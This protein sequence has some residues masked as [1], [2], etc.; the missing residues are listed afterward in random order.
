[1]SSGSSDVQVFVRVR[2]TSHFAQEVIRLGED[3]KLIDIHLKKDE[4]LGMVNNKR[5]DWSFKVDGILHNASQG[6]MYDMVAK[7]VVSRALQGYNGTIMCYGQTG[8]GKTFTI[9]GATENYKNRGII[10]RALQQVFKE[11]DEQSDRTVTVRIS[12]LEIYNE[13]LFDL[14]STLPE[15]PASDT[16]MTIVDDSQGVFVKGLSLHHAAD[17]EHALNLLFEGETN[18]IIGSHTLNK[19]SSRSHC[20]FT[21][22][23]ESHSRTLSNAKYT[24]SKLNLVDLAGS[25]RLGKTGSEGQVLKEASYIN[26]SLSFLEQTIIALADRRDYIP[27]RQSKLTHALKDSIGGNCNTIL[28]ANVYGEAAQIVETLSTLR[29]ASRMKCIPA[30][31]VIIERYDPVRVSKNLQREIDHLRRELAVHDNLTKHSSSSYEPFTDQQI[32]EINSQV[33]RYLDGT[34]DE[35]DIINLRQIQE[36]F[37]QFKILLNRQE[38]EVEARLREKYKLIDKNDYT[39]INAAQKA[40]VLDADGQ[41]VG[42]VDGSS[43][44]IGLAPV[45]SKSNLSLSAKKSKG[46]KSKEQSSSSR[47]EDA[48]SPAI[49]KD[50]DVASP[51]KTMMSPSFREL[52]VKES[53][54]KEQQ[55]NMSMDTQR[56]E[57]A[58]REETSGPGT[59]PTKASAFEEFK[60]ER[61]SELNRIFKENKLTLSDQRRKLKEVTERINLIKKEIDTTTQNL[62]VAKLER[63]KQ[64]EYISDEGQVIIDEQEFSLICRLKDLKK[65]YRVDYDE[66]QNLKAEVQYC[67]KLV[68]MCRQRLLKEFEIWYTESFVIPEDVQNS[69]KADGPL[70]P[71]MIPVN[72]LLSLGEDDQERHDKL[73]Q[74]LL[75][76]APG[77]LPF[78]NARIKTDR[79]HNYTRAQIQF[80]PTKKKAGII[81]TNVKNKPPSEL[82]AV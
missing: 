56:S 52:D 61:G 80:T 20:V 48:V 82:M 63:E 43:F 73:Q 2:P 24:V 55:E 72:K 79:K 59:P 81:T 50:L 34:L 46:R 30:E 37:Y 40:G 4:N 27:F 38:Q 8:A 54:V 10:P 17:E 5:Y 69:I 21:I 31:S 76:E 19:N 14:L 12:Y 39:A 67:Q 78:N 9:T 3:D 53:A 23:L 1:M 51:S 47:R 66:L 35:I 11:I 57:P 16:P 49:G 7:S 65:Q 42:E 25:E 32:T 77:S 33:R 44:S 74:E 29:F 26:K 45:S 64:G 28:V 60:A 68:D 75:I 58:A 70:R 6:L 22:H 41:L 15:V 18:R 62:N 13:T 71:W 36:V